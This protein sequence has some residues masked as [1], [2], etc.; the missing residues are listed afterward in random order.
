MEIKKVKKVNKDKI[1]MF[2]TN[3][4]LKCLYLNADQLLNKME[5]LRSVIADDTPD[6]IM[7]TEVIPKA[8]KHPI[9]EP[10]LSL[11]GFETFTN[12]T[13]T[14]ENLGSSGKRGVAIFVNSKLE[15]ELVKLESTYDDHLWVQVKLEL[16]LPGY[17]LEL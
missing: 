4:G 12:F 14:E 1:D 3:E 15:T 17:R 11:S 9:L 10:L 7:I 6:L 8:Q 13:F 16:Q 2:Q 5:D